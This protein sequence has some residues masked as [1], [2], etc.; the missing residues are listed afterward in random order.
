MSRPAARFPGTPATEPSALDQL[1]ADDLARLRL[2][3][4]LAVGFLLDLISIARRG[5]H[6]LDTLLVSAVIQANVEEINRRGDLQ[7]AFAEGDDPPPDELRRPIS[8]N[9]LANSLDLPFETVRRRIK[10]LAQQ[11]TCVLVEGG[12]VIVPTAVLG[13]PEYAADAFRGFERIRTFYYQLYDLGLLTGLPQPSVRLSANVFPIRAVAR[14]AGTYVLRVVEALGRVGDLIDGLI[15]LEIFRSNIEHLPPVPGPGP[16]GLVDDAQRRPI[17]VT[18]LAARIGVPQETV[19]RH[20]ADLMARGICVRIR[21]GLIVP[22]Q[23]LAGANPH[24]RAAVEANAANLH[25]LYSAYAQ[26]GVLEVW[27]KARAQQA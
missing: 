18:A 14:L 24:L 23:Q 3:G 19:R 25:R 7:M 1:G 20:V 17:A 11:G 21:G 2:T 15:V 5:G 26:L 27:D 6:V 22:M 9:G 13:R 8:M 4:R 12:G 16:G 10:A